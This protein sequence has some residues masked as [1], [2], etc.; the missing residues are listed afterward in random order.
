MKREVTEKIIKAMN[1]LDQAIDGLASAVR[2][3]ED[4][5]ERKRMLRFVA[6][7]IH[8]LHMQVTLPAIKDYPE[9][10]PDFPDGSFRWRNY[11]EFERARTELEKESKI[12]RASSLPMNKDSA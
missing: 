5:S 2:E 8:E 11:E 4:E 12:A 9:L 6:T 10:H 7:L 1:G 3:I